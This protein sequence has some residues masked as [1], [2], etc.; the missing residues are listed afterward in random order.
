MK[1][2]SAGF[3]VSII[4]LL[5]LIPS[6]LVFSEDEPVDLNR[7][8][9]F[10]LSI[11]VEFQSYTPLVNYGAQYNVF[12]IGGN[13]RVPIPPLPVLQPFIKG[14]MI[15]FDG[16]DPA[17]PLKWDNSHWFAGAGLLATHRFAKNFEL[18]GDLAASY[19]Q[20]YFKYL[21]PE[22][23]TVGASNIIAD[24]GLRIGLNPVTISI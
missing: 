22:S 7:Y 17:D 11:G 6:A 12:E 4:L 23:G 20:S 3:F 10:P 13:V 16:N 21:D 8:Y 15:I 1:N 19:T 2:K 9:R 18:G 5:L 14:G 24:A